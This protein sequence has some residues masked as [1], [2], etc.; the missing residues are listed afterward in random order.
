M[1]WVV[2]SLFIIIIIIII[3]I[4]VIIVIIIIVIITIIIVIITII[5]INII[6]IIVI[7]VIIIINLRRIC[8]KFQAVVTASSTSSG[9]AVTAGQVPESHLARNNV[10]RNQSHVARSSQSC[11][12]K[13]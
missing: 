12:P 5:I 13:S 8:Y 11:R 7:I 6:I 4:L 3:I 9:A 10:A 2:F 1:L